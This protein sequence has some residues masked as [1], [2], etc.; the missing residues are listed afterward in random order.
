MGQPNKYQYD[1]PLSTMQKLTRCML[2][3]AFAHCPVYHLTIPSC[4]PSLE[5]KS[6][7]T[8]H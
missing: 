4:C 7:V 2:Q 5:E 3:K 8:L 1:I 6:L